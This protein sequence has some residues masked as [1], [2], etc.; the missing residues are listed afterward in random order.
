M[1]AVQ[2]LSLKEW[3]VKTRDKICFKFLIETRYF[4]F[5]VYFSDNT[6]INYHKNIILRWKNP[7]IL[8]PTK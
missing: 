4:L 5:Q 2:E 6:E 1:L 8:M 7:L 3:Y